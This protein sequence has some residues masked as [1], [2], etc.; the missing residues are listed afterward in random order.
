MKRWRSIRTA[1]GSIALLLCLGGCASVQSLFSADEGARVA[2]T[3]PATPLVPVYRLEIDA[4]GDIKDLLSRYLDLSRY[5]DAPAG[6]EVTRA[7]IDRLMAAAPAQVRSLLETEGYFSPEVKVSRVGTTTADTAGPSASAA[8]DAGARVKS[9]ELPRLRLEVEPGRRVRI[10]S[11]EFKATGP[12]QQAASEGDL[13]AQVLVAQVRNEWRLPPDFRFRQSAWNDAKNGALAKLRADGYPAAS[14]LATSAQVDE[15]S[16]RVALEVTAASG[17]LYRLGPLQIKGL[18]LFGESTVRNLSTLRPGQPYRES[19]LLDFQ[20]RLQ[21]AGLFEGASVVLDTS[22]QT[23]QAAPVTV[24]VRELNR[25]QATFGV[26]VSAN[27]GPRMTAEHVHRQPFGWEWVAKNK[28]ELGAKLQ[29]WTGELTSYPLDGLYRQL[30]AANIERLDTVDEVRTS[31]SMRVGVTQDTPRYERL[32]FAEITHSRLETPS[33]LGTLTSDN[34][35][36]TGNYHWTLRDLDSTL[37]PTEGHTLSAQAGVGYALSRRDDT[38]TDRNGPFARLYGRYTLYQPL[39]ASWY[40]TA[41]VEAGQILAKD[42]VGVPDTL[43]F[44]A[45][46]DDSVRGYA[47]RSLGPSVDG[48]LLS[49]RVMLTGSAEIARPISARHPAFWWAAFIDAGNA[50]DHWQDLHPVIGYGVGL[51]WRSPVGPLRLDLA[52]GD[53]ARAWRTHLSVGIAF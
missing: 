19:E 17:D 23:S 5:Q 52:Y 9:R 50:A 53:D 51:C 44:R 24:R 34:S 22:P 26:G 15:A 47:Y 38:G 8:G 12:L 32:A 35:A 3:A 20:E 25:Q 14:W 45:G 43:L 30:L 16:Q 42:T 37:L 29:S 28:L 6:D 2:A 48:A 11:V 10:G 40:A 49:G 27:T 46:G 1:A 21:R 39:G 41:R 31:S 13:D 18:K 33:D 36:V 7:E 4:P